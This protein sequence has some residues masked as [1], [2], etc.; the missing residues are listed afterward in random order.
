MIAY[1]VGISGSILQTYSH[2]ILRKDIIRSPTSE[3]NI[4]PLVICQ[5]QVFHHYDPISSMP[6]EGLI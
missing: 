6:W 5:Q 2:Y 3:R 1:I 4:L